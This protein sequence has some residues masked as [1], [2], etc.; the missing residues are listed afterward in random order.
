MDLYEANLRRI[1][2]AIEVIRLSARTGEGLG[3]WIRWLTRQLR[4]V[5]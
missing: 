3:D 5:P 2:P 1:N 4:A